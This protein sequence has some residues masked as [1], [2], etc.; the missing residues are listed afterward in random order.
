MGISISRSARADAE[1]GVRVPANVLYS[2]T[3]LPPNAYAYNHTHLKMHPYGQIMAA[4]MGVDTV[5]FQQPTHGDD[6]SSSVFYIYGK[7]FT[8]L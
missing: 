1:V 2:A 7:P 3:M 4:G 5:T 6:H 8:S